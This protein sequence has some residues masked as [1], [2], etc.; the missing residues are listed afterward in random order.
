MSANRYTSRSTTVR[1]FIQHYMA[2]HTDEI[3]NAQEIMN[4][5]F[6]SSR[7]NPMT[8]AS[9]ART[10]LS[11]LVQEGILIATVTYDRERHC[12]VMYYQY[13]S[14]ATLSTIDKYPDY[15]RSWVGWDYLR[16]L[17][18]HPDSRRWTIVEYMSALHHRGTLDYAPI[19]YRCLEGLV[20]AQLLEMTGK[21][22]RDCTY[23]LTQAGT[24]VFLARP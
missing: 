6:R 5:T 2:T 10:A 1:M 7:D 8:F 11:K 9:Q 24:D 13:A 22:Y 17:N 20:A 19:V 16:M 21:V 4:R 18:Q 15:T 3:L 23:K 12:R 14:S